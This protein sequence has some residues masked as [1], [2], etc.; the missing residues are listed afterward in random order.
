MGENTELTSGIVVSLKQETGERTRRSES[1]YSRALRRLRHDY[2]TLTALTLLM[3]LLL[4]ALFA[5]FI[6]KNILHVDP[7]AT[8]PAV[9]LLPPGSPDH[10]LGTDD[11]GRDYAAR[12]LYGG[13][14]SLAIGFSGAFL[15]LGIGIVTGL[16]AGYYGGLVDDS[17]NWVITT[18]D[19]IPSI[20]LL[21]LVSSILQRSPVTLVLVISLL[22]WTGATRLIRGQTIAIR[23]LEYVICARALGASAWRVM[24]VH[25]LPN[26]LS[27][28]FL[29]LA[30]GIGGLILVESTLSF[31]KLGVQPPTPTWGNML[32]NAQQFFTRGP[33]MATLSGILIFVTVLCLFII[34]DGLRDAFDPNLNN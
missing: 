19:S 15:T 28:M 22:G 24:F 17:M 12:L 21:L 2:L 8:N 7:E 4:L 1:L 26:I 14:I 13:Q 27:L 6:T 34:G 5:P 16:I 18:L 33:H 20:Y 30:S 10:I 9:R 32:S 11:L 29:S 3:L 23:D 25:I 31:L